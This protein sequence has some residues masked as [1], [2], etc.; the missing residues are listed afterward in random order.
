[1]E[2]VMKGLFFNMKELSRIR[3]ACVDALDKSE[4]DINNPEL[5]KPSR[6]YLQESI[7]AYKQIIKKIDEY[8]REV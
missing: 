2:A 5:D 7:Q 4:K 3:G 1:M 6:F 8:R